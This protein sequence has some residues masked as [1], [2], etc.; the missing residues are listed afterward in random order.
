MCRTDS[1]SYAVDNTSYVSGDSIDDVT[2]SF[3][4][5]SMNLFK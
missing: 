5:D 4:D 3:K 2:K 1:E